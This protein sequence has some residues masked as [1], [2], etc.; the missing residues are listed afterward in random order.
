MWGKDSQS[1]VGEG[2]N[3]LRVPGVQQVQVQV[4][5]KARQ[6]TAGAARQ[7]EEHA[8]VVGGEASGRSEGDGRGVHVDGNGDGEFGGHRENV[9]C[10]ALT[11][12]FLTS[13]R[14]P[15]VLQVTKFLVRHVTT[16]VL[17]RLIRA[18][19]QERN[20]PRCVPGRRSFLM[21]RPSISIRRGR[22]D[23]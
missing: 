12:A 15:R 7:S 18:L 17:R 20:V 22:Q 9:L 19:Q 10:E 1:G 21:A 11:A 8:D 14:V 23:V 6:D 16:L 4:N 5:G 3:S 13:S 2:P